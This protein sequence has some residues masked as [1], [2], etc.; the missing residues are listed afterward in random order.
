[1]VSYERLTQQQ[2]AVVDGLSVFAGGFTLDAA[3]AVLPVDRRELVTTVDSLV[4]C[5]AVEELDGPLPRYDLAVP[6]RDPGRAGLEASGEAHAARARHLAWVLAFARR[7]G[8]AQRGEA[9]WFTLL[10]AERDNLNA[11]LAWGAEHGP[12][13]DVLALVGGLARFWQVRGHVAEG[14]RWV[15]ATRPLHADAPVAARASA[16]S[17]G[18]LLALRAGDL[19]AA[20]TL[21]EESLALY[22]E[23]DDRLGCASVLHSLGG[24]AFEQRDPEAAARLFEESLELGRDLAEPRVI[25]ASLTNLGAV[26]EVRGD[27]VEAQAR[28]REA[29]ALYDQ[30]GDAHNVAATRSNLVAVA[31]QEGDLVTARAVGETALGQLRELGDLT[32][33]ADMLARLTTIAA[34]EGDAG[35]A[36]AYA[37]E[38]RRLRAAAS[39]GAWPARL[40]RRLRGALGG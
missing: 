38:R 15:E 14:R 32:G 22:W 37:R 9:D 31:L 21:Y 25:A 27:L 29:L 39:G 13:G 12:A 36:L 1:M 10:E 5:G 3:A 33:A 35:A 6:L 19:D 8:I 7:G 24:V 11:A 23:E 4:A 26:A 17:T 16:A 34:R 28:Y 18:G 2:R 30:L 20:R 40:W